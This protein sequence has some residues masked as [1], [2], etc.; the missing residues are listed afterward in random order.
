M[1]YDSLKNCD[2]YTSAHEGFE[3]A[4]DF[5]KRAEAEKLSEGRYEIDGDKVYAFIQKYTSKTD[6]SFE[7][8]KRYIDI[9]YIISG[10]EVMKFADVEAFTPSCD[11]DGERDVVFFD[12]Y[13]KAGTAVVREGEYGIFFP[14]DIH[15]PGRIYGTEPAPV[16]K[17]V[18][19]I[20][21]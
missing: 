15:K 10:T 19:K 6:N 7:A 3:K 17:I 20:A 18:V 2:R 21:V 12:D 1:I 13:E 9:Q 8:H 14:H 5:I 4:F 11:Y 16:K